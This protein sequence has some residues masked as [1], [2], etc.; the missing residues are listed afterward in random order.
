MVFR[1]KSFLGLGVFAVASLAAQAAQAH[2]VAG[3][4]VFVNTLLIDD[5]GVGDEADLPVLS[6]QS[7]D[8]KTTDIGADFEYDK[9]IFNNVSLAVADGYDTLLHDQADGGKNY[10]G[11]G[12]LSLQLKYRWIVLPE[13]EFISSW[14]VQPNFGRAGTPGFTMASIPRLFRLF[15]QRARRYPVC[16]ESGLSHSPE[17][18][19]IMS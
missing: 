6:E 11:F 16:A 1:C 3:A 5:P 2:A 19:T 17:S 7:P 10:G 4:R 9:T 12:D 18:W 13:H 15:R 14:A 8:G